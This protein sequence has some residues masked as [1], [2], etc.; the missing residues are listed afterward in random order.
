MSVQ[1]LSTFVIPSPLKIH[2]RGRDIEGQLDKASGPSGM[3]RGLYDT[4]TQNVRVLEELRNYSPISA[5]LT[6]CGVREWTHHWHS[7]SFVSDRA[8]SEPRFSDAFLP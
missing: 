7:L 1:R 3:F 2:Y 5:N 4:Q 8:G 6:S